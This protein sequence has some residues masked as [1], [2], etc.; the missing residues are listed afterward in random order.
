M[1]TK[2]LGA[3]SR[4]LVFIVSAPAGTGKTTLVNM[5]T[6]EFSCVVAGISF[7]TRPP[8]QG[9]VNGVH[10]YFISEEEFAQKISKGEFLE[11]VRLYGYYYGSSRVWLEAQR[12]QGKHV[13]LVIDT[14]GT[15]QLKGQIDATTIFIRPPS[16]KELEKRLLLRKSEPQDVIDQRVQWAHEEMKVQEHYDYCIINDDLDIAYQALRSIVIAQEHKIG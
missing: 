10:Y 2:L 7:T 16:L 14:Q 15:M 9:E 4:G 13:V 11:Y 12:S 6:E 1:V 5:L 3:L 8:R